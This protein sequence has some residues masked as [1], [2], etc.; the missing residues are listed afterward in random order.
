V[1]AEKYRAYASQLIRNPDDPETLVNQFAVLS[2]KK[3]NGKHYYYL[4]KRA[5]EIAPERDQ[6]GIQ[7]RLGLSSHRTVQGGAADVP[8]LPGNG[9]RGMASPRSPIT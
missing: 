3:E 7:L 4:A 9:G 2:E 8:A 1:S 5:Y 6:R